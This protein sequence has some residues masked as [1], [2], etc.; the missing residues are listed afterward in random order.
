[1]IIGV[2]ADGVAFHY[3][4][5]FMRG[6]R[7][8]IKQWLKDGH[9]VRLVT[10]RPFM[11]EWLTELVMKLG[12]LG[13]VCVTHVGLE[14]DKTEHLKDC[15]IVIDNNGYNLE[16]LGVEHRWL[17]WPNSGISTDRGMLVVG[18]WQEIAAAYRHLVFSESKQLIVKIL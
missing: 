4:F 7:K 5:F 2:D 9:I 16:S 6:A 17:F 12:G 1:M 8:V 3:W 11:L 10:A 15:D 13:G 14:N 18:N